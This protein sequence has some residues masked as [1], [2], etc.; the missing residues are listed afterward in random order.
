M[1]DKR[2]NGW[3][4]GHAGACRIANRA[5]RVHS[6]PMIPELPP[7]PR[8]TVT[9]RHCL[10]R[11]QIEVTALWSLLQRYHPVCAYFMSYQSKSTMSHP[12]MLII[13]LVPGIGG[14]N[15]RESSKMCGQNITQVQTVVTRLCLQRISNY[16]FSC[17]SNDSKDGREILCP[18]GVR[19]QS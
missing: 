5:T 14:E 18:P 4:E 7:V 8:A 13:I 3:C 9:P 16:A 2:H 11:P 10:L 6:A 15:M 1:S 17:I 19:N 12:L